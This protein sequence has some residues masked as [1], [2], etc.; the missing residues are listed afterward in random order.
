MASLKNNDFESQT[1]FRQLLT[2]YFAEPSTITV[3][4]TSVSEHFY[5]GGAYVK[6]KGEEMLVC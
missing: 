5:P 2:D 1:K 3:S 4:L 6:V